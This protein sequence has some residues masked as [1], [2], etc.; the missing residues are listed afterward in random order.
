MKLSLLSREVFPCG[1]FGDL[2]IT[3]VTDDS[4]RVSEGTLFVAI[5]GRKRDGH[6]FLSQAV[7]GGAAGLVVERPVSDLPVPQFTVQN[8]RVAYGLL[9]GNFYGNPARTMTLTGITGT[10]G[11]TSVAYLLDHCLRTCGIRSAMIGTVQVSD[12]AGA[13]PSSLTTPDPAVLHG[14]LS[15]AERN[16]CTHAVLEVSS[17]SLDQSRTAGLEFSLGIFT[18]LS[19]D[20]LDYHGSMQAYRDAKLKLFS[21]CRAGLINSD[22][23][24]A[25]PFLALPGS[26]SFSVCH[27]ADFTAERVCSTAEGVSYLERSPTGNREVFLPSRGR[28]SVYNSLAALA[29]AEL[30]G[31]DPDRCADALRSFP[32]VPGRL[33]SVQDGLPFRLLIDYA[34][35]PDGLENVLRAL[36][37]ITDGRLIVL[38]GCGG[39]RDAGKRPAMGKIA[40]DY[41]DFAVI[42][43]DN[44]RS[45]D[46]DRIIAQILQGV[47]GGS[48][49]VIPDREEAIRAVIRFAGAGDTVLLA[50]KGH[51]T[52]QIFSDRTVRCNE[53]EIARKILKEEGY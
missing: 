36:R 19:V 7:S 3:S 25:A 21:Q 24:Y 22:S 23:D 18:N 4:R 34:H 50:G 37:E 17:Q 8:S 30:L 32:G 26:R 10:N 53:K 1:P 44:P 45:E 41:A 15:R 2:E 9:C 52:V 14:I 28:F 31:L 40:T 35:T 51:E 29:A 42:T 46:P 27:G 47:C 33:E 43:S 6:G 11:K 48:W 16:R 39:D 5:S 49:R 20:H 13:D 38:F 12:G